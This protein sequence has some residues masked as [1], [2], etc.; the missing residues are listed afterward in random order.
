M[1]PAK[2]ESI[3]LR[4]IV[5][6]LDW[7][8]KLGRL[9]YFRINSGTFNVN[10]RYIKG[11]P[12]GTGDIIVELGPNGKYVEIEVKS[13]SGKQSKIQ[14]ENQKQVEALGGSY[15]LAKSIIDVEEKISPII[16][17]SSK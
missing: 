2:K 16:F 17:G 15:I 7:C 3:T 11:A 8:Q 13:E 10:G 9:K 12:A 14:R 6:Y 4:A 1:G 5:D